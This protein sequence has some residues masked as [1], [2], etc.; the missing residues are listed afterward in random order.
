MTAPIAAAALACGYH[1]PESVAFKTGVLN[2][3]Y[4]DSLHVHAPIWRAQAAGLLPPY[5]KFQPKVA[6]AQQRF[7]DAVAYRKT[8]QALSAFAVEAGRLNTDSSPRRFSMVLVERALWAQFTVSGGQPSLNIDAGG[9]KQGDLVAVTGEP[10]LYGMQR[11]R[12]TLAEAVE[13][14]MIKLYGEP[15][16]IN[17][18]IAEYGSLGAQALPS[19]ERMSPI[20]PASHGG[21]AA[22]GARLSQPLANP[23]AGVDQ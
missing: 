10:V 22:T 14:G 15:E 16:A 11:G 3:M 13:S 1:D 21:L 19:V 9:P 7:L 8:E 23:S 4:P 12:L 6:S 20:T 2:W 5:D 17:G 18:F